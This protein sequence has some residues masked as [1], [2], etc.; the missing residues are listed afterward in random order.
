MAYLNNIPQPTDD[1]ATQSQAQLLE[2][3][4]QL[5]TQ[6][7][8]DHI[9]LIAGAD[10]GEHTKVTINDVLGADPGLADPKVS[11]YTKTVAGDSE[12]FFEKFDNGLAANLVQQL[13]NLP[14]TT[15]GG[16]HGITTPWGLIINFGNVVV[17]TGGTAVTFPIAYPN[18]ALTLV[19]SVGNSATAT[20]NVVHSNLTTA[21]FTANP[22]N[23]GILM[24]YFSIGN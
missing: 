4:A 9:P 6:F 3:F 11:V 8:V 16:A 10:N 17:N 5:N 24:Y 21:G 15:V 19:V 22:T 20:Q 2:N 1:P 23:N 7:A 18:N 13:T 14:L 12:L